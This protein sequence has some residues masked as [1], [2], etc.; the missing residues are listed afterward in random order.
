MLYAMDSI[1]KRLSVTQP[2]RSLSMAEPGSFTQ[3]ETPLQTIECGSI[4]QQVEQVTQ[5]ANRTCHVFLVFDHMFRLASTPPP[6]E[7][8]S[9]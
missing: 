7:S 4:K 9:T 2:V 1:T 8:I 6:S 5:R 3:A